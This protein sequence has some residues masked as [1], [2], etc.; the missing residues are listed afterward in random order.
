MLLY[1]PMDKTEDYAMLQESINMVLDNHL[2]LN[3]SD[4]IISHRKNQ[5]LHPHLYLGADQLEKV[6]CFTYLGLML[7]SDLSWSK[8]IDSICSKAKRLLGLLYRCFYHHIYI[9][10]PSGTLGN[11]SNT[12]YTSHRIRKLCMGSSFAERQMERMCAKQWD[13]GTRTY[14]ALP[15][16]I[17]RKPL[18]S[19]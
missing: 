5:V 14:R 16:A 9:Y 3:P 17:L 10:F 15:V 19:H 7:S 2:K 11:A 4:M 6:D 1:M 8:H 18:T 13:L 12:C